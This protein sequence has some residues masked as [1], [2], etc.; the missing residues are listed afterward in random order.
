MVPRDSLSGKM[1]MVSTFGTVV[2]DG[3]S[4]PSK[5]I[6]RSSR[7]GKSLRGFV[8]ILSFGKISDS[9]YDSDTENKEESTVL[10]ADVEKSSHVG[11]A[12][13]QEIPCPARNNGS[14]EI[15]DYKN[16]SSSEGHE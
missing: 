10:L 13:W 9:P 14:H 5:T 16:S 7:I 2:G 4:L 3:Q 11:S 15:V 8:K 1:S 12:P 6:K